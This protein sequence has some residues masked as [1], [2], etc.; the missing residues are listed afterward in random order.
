MIL[1]I[2]MGLPG[3]GKTTFTKKQEDVNI[4]DFDNKYQK[5]LYILNVSQYLYRDIITDGLFISYNDVF[6]LLNVF[7]EHFHKISIVNIEYWTPDVQNCLFND[8]YR[9]SVSSEITIKNAVMDEMNDTFISNLETDFPKL[10]GKFT[11]NINK[12]EKKSMYQLFLDKYQLSPDKNGC[13][14]N[15]S[16]SLG[17]TWQDCWGSGGVIGEGDRPYFDIF[18]KIINECIPNYNNDELCNLIQEDYYSEY[19]YY[20]GCDNRCVEFFKVEHLYNYLM[21]TPFFKRNEVIEEL[22]ND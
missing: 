13:I 20:G 12:V 22:L 21:E 19:D 14:Y 11:Y 1:T 2:C 6:R 3:S 4:W 5:P 18:Y 17:G 7:N 8:K 9:R 15:D 16:W 10:K